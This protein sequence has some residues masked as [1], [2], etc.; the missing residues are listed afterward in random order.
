M[1]KLCIYVT[2]KL[3]I[4]FAFT[5]G[6]RYMREI[7]T[8]K[9]GSHIKKTKDD[10]K[11]EDRFQKNAISGSHIRGIADKKTTYNKGCLYIGNFI[12]RY[13]SSGYCSIRLFCLW[14]VNQNLATKL[15]Y[16]PD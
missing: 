10:G 4:T 3:Q 6:P 16:N 13:S 2:A 11:L 15:N 1:K 9:V 8:P 7:E 12:T 5:G 14:I